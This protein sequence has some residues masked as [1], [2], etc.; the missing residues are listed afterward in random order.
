MYIRI[1]AW[2]ETVVDLW[3]SL[4]ERKSHR[5]TNEDEFARI[6]VLFPLRTIWSRPGKGNNCSLTRFQVPIPRIFLALS[7]FLRVRVWR[8]ANWGKGWLTTVQ[9]LV[10]LC[11]PRL[12]EG[13]LEYSFWQTFFS[14]AFSFS[15][16]FQTRRKKGICKYIY[17]SSIINISV[18]SRI[19]ICCICS[20]QTNTTNLVTVYSPMRQ[21]YD[22]RN[23]G[24]FGRKI[25]LSIFIYIYRYLYIFLLNEVSI[26]LKLWD[27][28]QK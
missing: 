9:T 26:R 27:N 16:R 17:I 15:N 23:V 20:K 13:Q 14:T 1:S 19:Q 4:T 5:R 22:Y 21:Y 7:F 2:L 10:C 12:V 8:I 3:L 11:W 28:F 25:Y 6:D 18:S 24:D